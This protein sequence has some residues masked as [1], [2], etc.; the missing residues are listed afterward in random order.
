MESLEGHLLVAAPQLLDP[1]FARALVLLVEHNQEGA[2]GVILNRPVGKTLQELWREVGSAPCHSHHPI[3]LGGPVPGPLLSL[4]TDPDLAE[5]E[6][7]PG[8]YFAA[9]KQHLD[10]LRHDGQTDPAALAALSL[11]DEH[12]GRQVRM[13]HLAFLGS[14]K[15][16]GV[17]ALHS[18]LV[19]ETVFRDLHA[20]FPDRITNVTNGVTFRRWLME[21][22]PSLT[23][24]LVET[25]GP[26]VLAEL[27]SGHL[28]EV[29]VADEGLAEQELLDLV[30]AAHRK[31]VKVRIAP[32]TKS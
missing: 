12:N 7:A 13:G 21:A 1:N 15:V 2:F 25:L 4:H 6:P 16:N 3:Y 11:I 5:T 23:R 27:S 18:E 24:L 9:K 32:R 20:V 29:I 14:H 10:K 31:G 28:H 17:S 26:A 30:E 22:N 19:K 8:V